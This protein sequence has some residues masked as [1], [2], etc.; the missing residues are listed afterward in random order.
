MSIVPV[1]II[2][3]TA[4]P[5]LQKQVQKKS[6]AIDQGLQKRQL[7]TGEKHRAPLGP[8]SAFGTAVLQ[9]RAAPLL[10]TQAYVRSASPRPGA[11]Q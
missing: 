11:E 5:Q 6:A 10:Y 2:D 3:S 8:F 4:P 9:Q 1:L 7:K